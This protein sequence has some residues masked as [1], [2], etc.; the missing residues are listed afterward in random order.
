MHNTKGKEIFVRKQ[1]CHP[2]LREEVIL[3]NRDRNNKTNHKKKTPNKHK[4]TQH[5][6]SNPKIIKNMLILNLLNQEK[7]SDDP[8]KKVLGKRLINKSLKAIA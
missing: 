2:K 8:N 3:Q 4:I 7:T 1:I 5:G 6:H